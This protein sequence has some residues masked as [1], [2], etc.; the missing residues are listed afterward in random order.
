M[1][2]WYLSFI[3]RRLVSMKFIKSTFSI[4]LCLMTSLSFSQGE[5]II[6]IDPTTGSF[7]QPKTPI[8]SVTWVQANVGTYDEIHGLF[9]FVSSSP[10]QKLLSVN[11]NDSIF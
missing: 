1:N 2:Y 3:T 8:D 10:T 11:S 9:I 6:E 7:I 4:L 5:F